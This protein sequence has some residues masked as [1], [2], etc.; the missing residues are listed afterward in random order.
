MTPGCAF[1]IAGF[2]SKYELLFRE[3]RAASGD[4][5][6]VRKAWATALAAARRIAHR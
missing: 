4:R 6:S 1:N 3:S 5:D 2:G